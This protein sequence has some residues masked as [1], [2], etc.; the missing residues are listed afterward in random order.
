MQCVH[1]FV[2]SRP[3]SPPTQ[4][5][6]AAPRSAVH[7]QAIL[8][9][10]GSVISAAVHVPLVGG[11]V[12]SAELREL[13]GSTLEQPIAMLEAFHAQMEGSR[14]VVGIAVVGPEV[15]GGGRRA[16][17]WNGMDGCSLSQCLPTTPV[18]ACIIAA[19]LIYVLCFLKTLCAP[20]AAP[21]LH[22]PCSI[23]PFFRCTLDLLMV[24]EDVPSLELVGLYPVN[25]LRN[26]ALMA[27]RTEVGSKLTLC[28]RCR[29]AV[30]SLVGGGLP[31]RK[32]G[33]HHCVQLARLEAAPTCT[34]LKARQW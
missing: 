3:L 4:A 1:A 23:H 25:A 26:R 17:L 32:C 28:R 30:N 16:R 31:P 27:V 9:A 8:Q 13:N 11:Q 7:Q 29:R 10:W 14:W 20:V 18:S 21:A 33:V 34:L 2:P 24:T 12:V 15:A 5:S 6:A 22:R 19:S